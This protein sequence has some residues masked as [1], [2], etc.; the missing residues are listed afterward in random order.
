M[1]LTAAEISDLIKERIAKLTQSLQM[2]EE[3]MRRV[4]AAKNIDLGVASIYR[5]VQGLDGGDAQFERKKE[6]MSDIFAANLELKEALESAL[7][8]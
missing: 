8:G 3:E 6:L 5:S 1:A 7:P 2:T 4:A